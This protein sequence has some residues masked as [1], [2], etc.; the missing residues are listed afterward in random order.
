MI[1]HILKQIGNQWG[2]NSWIMLELFMVFII[3]WYIVDIFS[4]MVINARTSTGTD[5]QNVHRVI[6]ATY[7]D[8]HPKFTSYEE[9][10]E[11]PGRNFLRIIERL[12]SHPDIES[13]CIG[14]WFY[15]YCL[16]S[17]MSLYFVDTLSIQC[18]NLRVS[19][20]YFKMF[21]VLPYNSDNPGLLEKAIRQDKA[22]ILSLEAN[23]RLFKEANGI[24]QVIHQGDTTNLNFVSGITHEMKKQAYARPES[25][26]LI[27][28]NEDNL[29]KQKEQQIWES[30]DICIKTKPGVNQADFPARFKAEIKQ[31]LAI[32][33]YFLAEI[34]PLTKIKDTYFRIHGITTT[35][36]YRI[37]ICLFFL[38]NIFLGVLGTFWLR[39]E[40][41][42][43]E[44]GLRMS[45]GSTRK[46]IMLL[47]LGES[48]CMLI[49]ASIP[50]L[51]VCLN[52]VYLDMLST[53]YM[54]ITAKRL[55]LNTLLTY[56]LL[57][58]VIT[59]SIWYP[60]QR[61]AAIQPAEALHN[62]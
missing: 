16:S 3:L 2:K 36:S 25:Y 8:G 12:R 35:L 38:I 39:I 17:N 20:E 45:V 49:I 5:I 57:T 61:S 32:G 60:A 41:R 51:L 14:Q 10:S 46:Q 31:Q 21:N 43:S 34:V 48:L 44:I 54:D 47:M 23:R 50:G 52:L 33:N 56:L 1:K 13:V 4:V 53:E 28:L 55:F 58:I 9:G 27:L 6:L 59:L 42:K 30:T 22:V 7:K 11:E 15:P 37:G 26:A 29:L 18:Q 24:G 19:P 62:E 40:K